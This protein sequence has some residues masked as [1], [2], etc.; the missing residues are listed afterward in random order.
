MCAVVE[1][2]LKRLCHLVLPAI[3]LKRREVR[4]DCRLLAVVRAGAPVTDFSGDRYE[5]GRCFQ[6]PDARSSSCGVGNSSLT[7]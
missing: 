5:Q 3:D 2:V 6:P 1:Y 7:P 4:S